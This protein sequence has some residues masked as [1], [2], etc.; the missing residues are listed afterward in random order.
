MGRPSEELEAS[1]PQRTV[2]SPA[3]NQGPLTRAAMLLSA[4]LLQTLLVLR[5]AA[6][7]VNFPSQ[8]QEKQVPRMLD[9]DLL[10][11]QFLAPCLVYRS[12]DEVHPTWLS[13]QIP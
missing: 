13:C 11:S 6:A 12:R 10:P 3:R 8:G 7:A 4:V 2:C 5:M 1:P 9:A